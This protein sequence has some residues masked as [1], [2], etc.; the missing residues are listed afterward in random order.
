MINNASYAAE[1]DQNDSLAK[2]RE[3]FNIPVINGQEQKYFL[4]NSLGLQPVNTTQHIQQIL[5]QWSDFGVEAFFEGPSPWLTLHDKLP[6]MLSDITGSGIH[7]ITIM[8]QLTVNLHLMMVSF[9]QPR[10]KKIKILCEEHA[11]PSDQ[12][13]LQSHVEYLGYDPSEVILEIRP[14][15]GS[16]VLEENDI[17][18]AIE[19]HHGE[20][21][22]ILLP[23]VQYYTGQIFNMKSITAKAHEFGI[24]CGFDLAHAVGNIPLSLH[25]WDIDFACWCSYKYLN[26]GP[27][28]I[29]GVFIHEKFHDTE[30]IQRFEGWWGNENN[31]RFLMEKKFRPEKNA[32][33]WQ[34]STPSPILYACLNASLSIFNEAGWNNILTKQKKMNAFHWQQID[35]FKSKDEK[36]IIQIITPRHEHGC[37]ISIFVNENGKNIHENLKRN[38]FITDWREPNVI[39]LAPVPLYNRYSE[40]YHFYQQLGEL[41][42][43]S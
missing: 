31:T 32:N 25:D 29:G 11:F 22:M 30:N 14:K 26:G 35:E 8:N 37:Q 19:T 2:Y 9:Y 21:A 41:I 3:R 17:L 36:N 28:T 42:H 6:S 4:G 5:S 18:D 12:Y 24:I 16:Y 20:L 40:I 34:L 15:S 7:E 10:G 39:R 38:G 1:L 43:P 13:M 27:G 33:A 23:G